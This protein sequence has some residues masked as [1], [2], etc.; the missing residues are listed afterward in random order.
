[1]LAHGTGDD[2]VHFQNSIQMVEG[3]IKAHK[4]FRFMVYPNKTHSI[5]GSDDR[6][7]LFHMIEDHFEHEL[8]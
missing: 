1:F 6:D 4:Q 8:K 3:L 5:R 7:H 2:N